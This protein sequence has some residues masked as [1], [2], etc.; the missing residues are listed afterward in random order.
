MKDLQAFTRFN[1]LY[2]DDAPVV[3]KGNSHRLSFVRLRMYSLA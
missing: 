1:P 2:G 3:R